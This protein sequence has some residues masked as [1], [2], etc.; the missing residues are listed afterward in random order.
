MIGLYERLTG[1]AGLSPHLAWRVCFLVLPV[2]LLFLTALA[3]MLFAKDHPAG[4]WKNRHQLPGTA[5]EVAR[6]E[7]VQL[8]AA[9][10]REQSN[11]EKA[12]S[13]AP[14][15]GGRDFSEV[16]TAGLTA[17]DTAVSEPLTVKSLTAILT[18]LRVWMVALCYLA[19]VSF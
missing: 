7:D 6:G 19:T 4:A 17:I 5:I 18:D 3:M 10:I 9:E 16:N 8:D 13:V 15:K 12:T 11:N 2:P 14:M 1:S